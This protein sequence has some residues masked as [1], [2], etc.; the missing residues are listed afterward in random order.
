MTFEQSFVFRC[1]LPVIFAVMLLP[2]GAACAVD[3]SEYVIYSFPASASAGSIPYGNLIA[4]ASGNLY[5]TTYRGGEF[6]NG[7]VFE[8]SRPAAPSTKWTETV[9]YNFPGGDD[10]SQPVAGVILDRAGNL[11]GT[12]SQG[13][14]S[15]FGTVFELAPPVAEGDQWTETAL[16]NF[17]GGSSDGG[18]PFAG[19]VFDTVGRLYGAT[20]EG[21]I[22]NDSL[23][24]AGCGTVFQLMPPA[25][26]GAKWKETVIH[27]FNSRLG[28]NPRAT[29]ILDGAGRLYGT[30]LLG[31]LHGAGVIFRLTPP[32]SASGAWTYRV[33]HPFSNPFETLD[34]AEPLASLTLHAGVLY[35]TT[36]AGGRRNN[37]TVYQLLPPALAGG[38][39]TENVLFS[40]DGTNGGYPSANVVFDKAGNLYST[41]YAGGGMGTCT[42]QGCGSVFK[43]TPPVTKGAA[44]TETVLHSF[45]N[46]GGQDGSQPSGGLVF[47]KNDVLFGVTQDGGKGGQGVVFGVI[48]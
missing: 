44:W 47:G 26:S 45:P 11:Y 18:S 6:S 31:G 37:G 8:L 41:T 48:P 23:C 33:L 3:P 13:G 17:E 10:G 28:G 39:W 22:T 19:L 30:T 38:E 7:T 35:G 25:S 2:G 5:G 34:S 16:Y 40:F 20:D 36:T 4:D 21:G 14:T 42:F 29:P 24:S 12:T 32:A 46:A 1:V 9:L 27:Y 43:L 15:G